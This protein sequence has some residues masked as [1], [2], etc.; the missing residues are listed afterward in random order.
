MMFSLHEL[1]LRVWWS[2]GFKTVVFL[3]GKGYMYHNIATFLDRKSSFEPSGLFFLRATLMMPP[4]G[5]TTEIVSNC[6]CWRKCE[7]ISFSL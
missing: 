2:L 5:V 6:D 4:T 3:D 1:V 7:E